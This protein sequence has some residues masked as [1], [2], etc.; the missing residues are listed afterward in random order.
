MSSQNP[1]PLPL[2]LWLHI[3]TASKYETLLKIRRNYVMNVKKL[4]FSA[5]YF[6][7]VLELHFYLENHFKTG[8]SYFRNYPL[9]P[10]IG[11]RKN[12]QHI[13]GHNLVDAN[14]SA[15]ILRSANNISINNSNNKYINNNNINCNNENAY[16]CSRLVA[17]SFC[18]R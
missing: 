3:W 16:L 13:K 14:H 2:R 5:K 4:L 1:W 17:F 12:Y 18:V 15:S 9:T 10:C 8:T 11:K 7:T 6:W